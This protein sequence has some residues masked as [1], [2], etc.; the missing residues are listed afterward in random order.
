MR[1]LGEDFVPEKKKKIRGVYAIHKDK[2]NFDIITQV[3]P[4]SY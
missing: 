2:S 4:H 3:V 1:N